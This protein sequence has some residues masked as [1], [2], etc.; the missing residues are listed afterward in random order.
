MNK[1]LIKTITVSGNHGERYVEYYN[2]EGLIIK[3]IDNTN[4]I[5][6]SYAYD[7]NNN[8]I[9]HRDSDNKYYK[10]DR[11]YAYK[12]GLMTESISNGIKTTYEYDDNRLLIYTNTDNDYEC[13]YIY[14]E[15][16]KLIKMYDSRGYEECYEYNKK[17]QLVRT[18]NNKNDEIL[19][20][21]DEEGN[22]TRYISTFSNIDISK[23]YD[24]E[25]NVISETHINFKSKSVIM[26]NMLYNEYGHEIN[27]INSNG[28]ELYFKYEYF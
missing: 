13:W 18:I 12:D 1:K 21:Y 3:R 5:I 25:G 11:S 14:D 15:S 20:E 24:E 23:T 22:Q 10:L 4:G 2:R 26:Y 19:R 7:S 9:Y 17:G 16:H 27:R 6:Q 28:H 8:L